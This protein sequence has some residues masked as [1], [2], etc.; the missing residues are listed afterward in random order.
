MTS[1]LALVLAL[2]VAATVMFALNRPRMDIVGFLV[3]VALPFTGVISGPEAVAGFADST[4]LLIAALFVVGEGLVRTGVA[5]RMGDLLAAGSGDSPFRMLAL[6]MAAGA[7]AGAVMSST[8]IVAILIPVVLRL[9][10]I[11]GQAPGGLMMPLS[12]GALISGMMTLI[13]TPPNIVIN[14]ELAR[15]GHELLGFFS[16]TPI[17]LPVLALAIAW[18]W[19]MRGTLARAGAPPA[20]AR[21]SLDGWAGEY[22]LSARARRLRVPAGSPAIGRP[23][24]EMGFHARQGLTILSVE[25]QARLFRQVVM[26]R[27]ETLLAEGD[28]LNLDLA[29]PAFPLETLARADGLELLPGPASWR[30]ALGPEMGLVE[31]LVAPGAD[32]IGR[33]PVEAGFRTRHGLSVIGV[34]RGRG[35]VPG[36]AAEAPL[37]P[38]DILLLSGPWKRIGELARP[39]GDLI[40][41]TLP[42]EFDDVAPAADRAPFAVAALAGMILL[43]V[44]GWTSNLQAAFLACLAMGVCGA[45]TM[46]AAYRAISWRTL[47]L[48]VGMLPFALALER[49]GGVTL[50]AEALAAIAADMGPRGSLALL[51][52]AAAGLSMFISNTATAVLMAPVAVELAERLGASPLPFAMITALGASTAFMTPVS[53][54]VNLL[55]TGPGGYRFMDFVKIGAPF[56]ALVLAVSVGLVPILIPF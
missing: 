9:C 43:M 20:A 27:A 46:D 15:R 28:V 17:G 42:A 13:G 53:S 51:F 52:L 6:V 45:I 4:V 47:M 50:A 11:R 48:I 31:A 19:L 1:D 7:F 40:A 18:M 38:G 24:S 30:E 41:L 54:P 56:S 29:E 35:I 23:L 44:T 39:G 3:I 14:G 5:A 25:R 33:S 26:P 34:K 21:A 37:R 32:L 10:R 16:F 8:A 2:L 55:V 36:P 12:M 22:G 49:T